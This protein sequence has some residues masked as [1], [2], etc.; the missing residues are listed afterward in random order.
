[1]KSLKPQQKNDVEG[2]TIIFVERLHGV[3]YHRLIVPFLRMRD[4]GLINLHVIDD[5]FDMMDFDLTHVKNFVVSRTLFA[6]AKGAEVFSKKLKDAGVKLIVDL[7]DYWEVEKSNPYF[8][9]FYGPDGMTNA[10]KRTVRIADEIWTPSLTLAKQIRKHLNPTA[11]IRIV[12][13]GIDPDYPMW[14]KE[15]TTG[16]DLWFGYL[17]ASSHSKDVELTSAV[18]WS[19]YKTTAVHMHGVDY[20]NFFKADLILEPLQIFEYGELYRNCDVSLVPLR[21]G[22]FNECKSSL[23]VA[24]AGFTRTAVIASNVTPY[25]EVIEHGTTGIL[26][27]NSDEWVEAVASMTKKEAKR[28]G[29]NLYEAVRVD[30]H[31]DTINQERLMGL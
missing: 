28:L 7:D 3:N 12:P 14:G 10:I 16:D 1:L 18:D 11:L 20:V 2:M 5:S 21:G 6:R 9:F 4:Q 19:Q 15:K 30:F 23:K 25:K 29:D 24:E 8:K 31:I 22:K 13:N 17:G 27:S 26:C